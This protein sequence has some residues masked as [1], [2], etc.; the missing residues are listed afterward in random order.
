MDHFFCKMQVYGIRMLLD[1]Y[2]VKPFCLA[3]ILFFIL[4]THKKKKEE[5]PPGS[6]NR[7]AKCGVPSLFLSTVR[8]I[9][10]K[11]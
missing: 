4:N 2:S 3:S 5:E 1:R 8:I 6:F 11:K 9:K 10:I 7:I